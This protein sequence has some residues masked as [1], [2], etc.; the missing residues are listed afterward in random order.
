MKDSKGITH[1][2][3]CLTSEQCAYIAGFVDGEG[4]IGF[5][6]VSCPHGRRKYSYAGRLIIVNTDREVLE[7]MIAVVGF[8]SIQT[9]H[10]P[11]HNWKTTYQLTWGARQLRAVLPLLMPYLKVRRRQA[12]IVW[13]YLQRQYISGL[14]L[15]LSSQEWDIREKMVADNRWLNIRGKIEV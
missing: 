6:K 10:H 13:A 4:S 15:G 12:E 8:G 7:W 1:L 11:N 3:V 2:K 5:N 14:K 9:R